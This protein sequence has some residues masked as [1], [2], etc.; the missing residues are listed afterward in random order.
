M[1]D[2]TAILASLYKYLIHI[3]TANGEESYLEV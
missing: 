3:Q 2:Q 1:T